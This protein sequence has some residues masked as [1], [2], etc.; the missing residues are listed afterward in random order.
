[1]GGT[2]L[3]IFIVF[4]LILLVVLVG[5]S[6]VLLTHLIVDLVYDLIEGDRYGKKNL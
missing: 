2:V 6:L 4:V 1:M 3:G 5:F